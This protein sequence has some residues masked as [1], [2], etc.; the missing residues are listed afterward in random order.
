[1]PGVP[2]A[3]VALIFHSTPLL[4]PADF[5]KRKI[6]KDNDENHHMEYTGGTW[7][8]WQG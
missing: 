1:M 2:S 6:L 5:L 4:L 7:G 3:S 8:R